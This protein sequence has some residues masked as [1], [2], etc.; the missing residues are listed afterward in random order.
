MAE[1]S[2][3]QTS[4]PAYYIRDWL[5][6]YQSIIINTFS[7]I[8][9]LFLSLVIATKQILVSDIVDGHLACPLIAVQVMAKWV[10]KFP[11]EWYKIGYIFC[12]SFSKNENYQRKFCFLNDA[13]FFD[14]STLLSGP[15]RGWTMLPNLVTDSIKKKRGQALLFSFWWNLLSSFLTHFNNYMEQ[16]YVYSMH[17][18]WDQEKSVQL[19]IHATFFT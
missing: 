4:D 17:V 19:K 9:S 7:T 6:L 10:V 8:L 5:I 12:S 16:A 11:K 3:K 13:Q 18:F 2:S 14:D 15:C 1:W